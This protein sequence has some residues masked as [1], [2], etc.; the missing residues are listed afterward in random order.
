MKPRRRFIR[1]ADVP[2]IDGALEIARARGILPTSLDT[3]G[4]RATFT[5]DVL[6]RSVFS[7]TTEHAGYLQSLEKQVEAVL[8]GRDKSHA[9]A[10][11][12]GQLTRLGY[13]PETGFDGGTEPVRPGSIQDLSSN[14]RL[15]LILDTQVAILHGRAQEVAGLESGALEQFPGYE[16]VRMEARRMPRDW[17]ARWKQAGGKVRKDKKGRVRL[18]ALKTDAVWERLG[19]FNIFSDALGISHPPFAFRS[20]MGWD[21]LDKRECI[22]LGLL[23]RAEKVTRPRKTPKNLPPA[24]ASTRGMKKGMLEKLREAL[25]KI[26][27]EEQAE[28]VAMKPS[29][30]TQKAPPARPQRSKP[31]APAPRPRMRQNEAQAQ[32]APRRAPPP[33]PPPRSRGLGSLASDLA[34]EFNALLTVAQL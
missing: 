24:V 16:L 8:D 26:E 3:E 31:S 11:L 6:A 18:V 34:A 27:I 28:S 19:D 30:T 5:K 4:I 9:R 14:A 17:L 15:D 13:S 12:K 23:K 25:R 21:E 10:I 1:L 7:A 32:S 20:G 22:A 29:Q 33:P 2:G